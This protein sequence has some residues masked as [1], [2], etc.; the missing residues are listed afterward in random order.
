MKRILENE[1]YISVIHSGVSALKKSYQPPYLKLLK[2]MNIPYIPQRLMNFVIYL[3]EDFLCK[4]Q[5][6][7]KNQ[8]DHLKSS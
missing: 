8:T 7:E 1:N 6:V 5:Y 4:I 2:L 3:L